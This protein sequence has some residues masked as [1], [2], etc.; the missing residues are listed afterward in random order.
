MRPLG[1]GL[2][3]EGARGR[4]S[5]DGHHNSEVSSKFQ[6]S[7]LPSYKDIQC[8]KSA[9]EHPDIADGLK[10]FQKCKVATRH[11]TRPSLIYGEVGFFRLN[12]SGPNPEMNGVAEMNGPNRS[13]LNVSGPNPM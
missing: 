2:G 1:L 8:V 6:L 3:A 10:W 11:K 13:G 9:L 5:F 4:A 7:R 12:P